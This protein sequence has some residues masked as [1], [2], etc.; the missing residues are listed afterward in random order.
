M[1]S[2]GVVGA[3][4]MGGGMVRRLC[5]QGWSV[6]LND[7][8][9]TVVAPLVALG[10]QSHP[11][12][13]DVAQAC[14]VLAIVVV[15]QAQV[16]AV[17]DGEQGLLGALTPDHT[18]L[19]CPTLSPEDVE[20]TAARIHATGALLIDAPMSG[21]P[22]RAAKGQMS[23]MVACPNTCLAQHEALL[24]TLAN[25]VFHVSERVGDGAR[26]K[27]VNNLL[28]AINW[29]G[30][31]E[32]MNLALRAGLNPQTTL[33]VIAS[34]SGQSWIGSDRMP[35]ALQADWAPRAHLSLLTKDSRL[36]VEMAQALDQSTPLGA[37]AKQAFAQASAA[38]WA[39][40][41]D[42]AML[43]HLR[44]ELPPP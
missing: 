19:L 40:F 8:D 37:L 39:G 22:T 2:F 28:A 16:D 42:A 10:A 17:L 20:R 11:S 32:V 18:V 4:N 15:D 29:V 26:T 9:A 31:S 44:G 24:N 41:D 30:A 13:R 34:S 38:G 1:K 12:A 14:Q 35:R 23:L 21:G 25:P 7:I 27:L 5:D 36:A 33:Q 6:H 43:A 3:G